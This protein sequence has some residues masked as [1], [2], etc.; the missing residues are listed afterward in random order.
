M[1]L[2]YY[3]LRENPF[4]LISDQRFIYYGTGYSEAMAHLLYGV[5]ERRGVILLLGEAG[6]GKT[7]L[8]RATLD[9]LK[10]TQVVSSV[11]F[12]PV[13]QSGDDLLDELLL[14]FKV[15]E[16]RRI[17]SEMFRVLVSL[18]QKE[19]DNKRIPVIV[20]DEAQLLSQSVLDHLRLLSNLDYN[21]E[22]LVQIILAGQPEM[23]DRLATMELRALKQRI[24]VRC[25]LRE[26]TDSETHRYV[27][28]RVVRAGGDR[29]VLSPQ[30]I[31]L[32]FEYSGGIPRL[33]NIIGDNALLA[34]FAKQEKVVQTATVFE[35]VQHLE[36]NPC[37]TA[38]YMSGV[39]EDVIRASSSWNEILTDVKNANIPTPIRDYIAALR[40]PELG[41]AQAPLESTTTQES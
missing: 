22:R 3:G 18:L 36:L 4:S 26:L 27:A 33:I 38:P 30:A 34:G 41:A 15:Q 39:R 28:Y 14:G 11:V 17:G 23:A 29:P 20:L 7:T 40:A 32:M 37:S 13:M 10:S 6:T 1:Y 9:A 8:I 21:G 5:R 31:E 35:V 12:N 16:Y 2:A 25:R 19:A 24:A